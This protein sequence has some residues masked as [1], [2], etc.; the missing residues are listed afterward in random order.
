MSEQ[1]TSP[2]P[3]W[4]NDFDSGLTP[5]SVILV[6]ATGTPTVAYT[7]RQGEDLTVQS[8]SADV[9]TQ[10]SAADV[11]VQ[12]DLLD[13]SGVLL[14]RVRTG[15]GITA[16]QLGQVT[17]A[18]ELPDSST[19][20]VPVPLVEL[21]TGLWVADPSDGQQIVITALEPAAIV[22]QARILIVGDVDFSYRIGP[23]APLR[24]S[25]A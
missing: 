3:P 24:M 10:A 16:G 13:P 21:Q 25:Q 12:C 7:T 14:A 1:F 18:P 4:P 2:G 8:I 11:P 22:T 17:F 23:V 9:D 19:F 5:A 15:S 6:S 20:P